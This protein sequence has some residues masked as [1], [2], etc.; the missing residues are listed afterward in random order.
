MLQ[1]EHGGKVIIGGNFEINDRF[2]APTL[3]ENP[4]LNSKMMSEEIFGPIL[5]VIV[6]NE[7]DEVLSLVNSRPKPLSLYYF[8]NN[9]QK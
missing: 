6:F 4:N 5:P 2:I 8:G 7:L 9:K 1:E 3:V